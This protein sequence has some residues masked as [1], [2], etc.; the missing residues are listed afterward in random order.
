MRICPD[1]Y[2][3]IELVHSLNKMVVLPCDIVNWLS[4]NV[5]S[6]EC[7]DSPG[8]LA[9]GQGWWAVIVKDGVSRYPLY[10]VRFRFSDASK[11][12]LFKLTW[13]GL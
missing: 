12:L 13:G 5:G 1:V 8:I 3:S 6:L 9:E 4:C 10:L 2:I 11:A 7:E